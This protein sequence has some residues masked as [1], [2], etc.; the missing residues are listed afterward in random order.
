MSHNVRSTGVTG[1]VWYLSTP[2]CRLPVVGYG[3]CSSSFVAS[4]LSGGYT[5][6][7]LS[8]HLGI[9]YLHHNALGDACTAALVLLRAVEETGLTVRQW[10]NGQAPDQK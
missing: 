4:I 8:N 7:N 6:D 1:G 10:Q 9:E 5:V 3:A 2:G